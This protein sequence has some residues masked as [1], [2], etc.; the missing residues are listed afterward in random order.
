M[1][2]TIALSNSQD[3]LT[4]QD[5][6]DTCG[7]RALVLVKGVSGSLMFCGHHY[8]KIMDNAVGYDKMMKFAY[9]IIDNR[10]KK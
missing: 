6:C 4:V 1:N 7:A 10:E 2:Q 5:R 8:N 3:I 9:E